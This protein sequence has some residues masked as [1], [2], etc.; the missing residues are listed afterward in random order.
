MRSLFRQ[1]MLGLALMGFSLPAAAQASRTWISGVGDD[2]NPG[3]RTAPC[4][5]FAG[6]IAKTAPGGEID[7]LDPGG[8]GAL[9]ITKAITLDG[10]GGQVGSVLVSGTNGIVVQAGASDVVIIRNLR[11]NGIGAGLN[12]IRFLSGKALII[13]N[14]DIF[15]FTQSGVDVALSAAANLSILNTTIIGMPGQSGSSGVTFDSGSAS[16]NATLTD[17]R[18]ADCNTNAFYFGVGNVLVRGGG[19]SNGN[20]GVDIFGSANVDLDGMT[21]SGATTGLRVSGGI[22]RLSD[23]TITRNTTGVTIT[24]GSVSTFGNNRVSG[25]GAGNGPIGSSISTQ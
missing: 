11:I 15:G 2:A 18:V 6:A 22:A 20:G 25:N 19:C 5:T 9:T 21:I 8:F 12:G 1:A 7:C 13:E 23:C 3:S 24:G 4:K 10:G 14:C 16:V 17:V